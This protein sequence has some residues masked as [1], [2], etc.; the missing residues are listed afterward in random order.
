[1]TD[2]TRKSDPI[3]LTSLTIEEIPSSSAVVASGHRYHGPP[4][5]Q[6]QTSPHSSNLESQELEPTT[7][8]ESVV[9]DDDGFEYPESNLQ[10]WL[11]VFGAFFGLL[12]TWGIPNSIGVIQTQ[13][14]EHQLSN[15]KMEPGD[16]CWLEQYCLSD[17]LLLWLTVP[18]LI[19]SS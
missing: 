19:N 14:L 15:V 13:I 4:P 18:K 16:H 10:G 2:I 11:V 6:E 8:S 17:H 7:S 3:K 12:P 1:M 5:V 9:L